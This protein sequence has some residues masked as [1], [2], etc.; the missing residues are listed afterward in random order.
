MKEVVVKECGRNLAFMPKEE[1]LIKIIRD[2]GYS[3]VM[4]KKK[5]WKFHN[6]CRKN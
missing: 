5:R 6:S 3:S 1:E 2:K 4:V